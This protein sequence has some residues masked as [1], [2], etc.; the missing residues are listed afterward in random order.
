MQCK[1][2]K[3]GLSFN[4][5][6]CNSCGARVVDQKLTFRYLVNDISERFF[7]WDNNLL[8]RTVKHMFSRPEA[9]IDGYI[10]GV[11][12]RYLSVANYIALAITLAGLLLFIVQKFFADSMDMSWMQ[13]EN[14]PV[15]ENPGVMDS[16]FEYNSL[17]YL[18]LIPLYALV[19]RIVFF[20]YKN[21]NYLGH[22]VIVAYTQA[23]LSIVTFIPTIIA[24]LLGVNYFMWS[25]A[26]MAVMIIYSSWVYIRL[27]KL[28]FGKFVL[29]LLLFFLIY[30]IFMIVWSILLW[31]YWIA[32]GTVDLQ[33]FIEANRKQQAMGYI[34]SSAMNWTS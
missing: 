25:F 26:I 28:S 1:N 27:F 34:I 18:L 12:K 11:R 32:S 10:N 19:S 23:H 29:K 3:N 17:F 30:I 13:Q 16:L 8:L 15:I 21:Y 33:E 31:I 6:F 7:D 24:L 22:I 4:D 9:V 20:N 5:R 2:C 14:N